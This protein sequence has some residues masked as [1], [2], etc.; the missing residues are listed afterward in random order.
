MP[1]SDQSDHITVQTEPPGL[2]TMAGE[3]GW[4]Q[5]PSV[6]RLWLFAIPGM[7]AVLALLRFYPLAQMNYSGLLLVVLLLGWL[8][9]HFFA[10]LRF[11][12]RHALL[13]H[14]TSQNSLVRRVFWNSFLLKFTLVL[15]SL[16]IALLALAFTATLEPMQWWVLVMGIAIFV[17][18]FHFSGRMSVRESS[19]QYN[20]S[21]TVHIA[22][23]LTFVV[24]AVFMVLIN[25]LWG[26][27]ADTRNMSLLQ[28]LQ[29]AFNGGIEQAAIREVGWL[30]G[31]NAAVNDGMWHLMQIASSSV[32]SPVWL[33]LSAWLV[34]LLA[35]AL[36]T[37]LVWIVLSGVPVLV[38]MHLHQGKSVLGASAFSRSFSISMLILFM[39]YL[40]LTQVNLGRYMPVS[41]ISNGI[42]LTMPDPCQNMALLQQDR[43]RSESQRALSAQQMD[44]QLRI[45]RQIDEKLDAAFAQAE[46]GVDRFLDWN[47]SLPG[48]YAQLLYMGRSTFEESA[49]SNFVAGKMDEYVG[50]IMQPVMLGV[51]TDLQDSFQNEV[52]ELFTQQSAYLAALAESAS[53]LDIPA[54]ELSLQDYMSKS[55]VGAGSGAGILAA[56]ASMRVGSRVVSRTASRRVVSGV[57]ARLS[58]RAATSAV[59]GTGGALCGPLVVVCAPALAVA[60]WLATDLAINEVDEALNRENMRQDM[61]AVLEE[62]KELRKAQIKENYALTLADLIIEVEQYQQ[63]RF[64]ILR[65]GV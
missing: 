59:A 21:V 41:G 13:L 40:A 19:Q 18:F 61:M 12:R 51:E 15:K 28:V 4:S 39:L 9:Y 43:I 22:H 62:E 56:R 47:F 29:D 11:M 38:G 49:L 17:L 64:N 20:L 60:A 42:R 58:S 54:P 25:L 32:D 24:L 33:K 35:A 23:W 37:G 50:G 26:N 10:P 65:D 6:V 27:A 16:L 2:P 5:P 53:C 8:A 30:L 31:I 48:Q 7:L 63:Q 14:V 46:V 3:P 44:L 45:E 52:T 1:R 55:P 57:F 34:F 36:K